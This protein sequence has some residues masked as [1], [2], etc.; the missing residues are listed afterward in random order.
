M[1][2]KTFLNSVFLVFLL[3]SFLYAEDYITKGPAPGEIYFTAPH[4][5]SFN[6]LA[7]YHS[8]DYGLTYDVIDSLNEMRWISSDSDSGKLYYSFVNAFYYS[9]NYGH[10]WTP[11]GM[12]PGGDVSSGRISGEIFNNAIWYSSDYGINWIQKTKEMD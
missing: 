6:G 10:N 2:L 8:W 1:N 11:R 4:Q 3:F 7:L 9:N 5:N 12:I